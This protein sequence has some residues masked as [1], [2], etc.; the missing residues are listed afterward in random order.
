MSPDAQR[1]AIAEACG[2]VNQGK[3]KGVPAL[4]YRWANPSQNIGAG[5]NILPDY[6]TDLNAMAEAE[7]MLV[8]TGKWIEYVKQLGLIFMRDLN[9][10]GTWELSN[11]GGED[12]L[13]CGMANYVKATAAQ[14]AESFLK[15]LNLWTT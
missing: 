10:K 11:G 7:K 3:A 2:W 8:T 12:H 14:R 5:S 6:L 1:V 9:G 13:A 4:N 15:T